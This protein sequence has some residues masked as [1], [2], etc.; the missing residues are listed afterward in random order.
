MQKVIQRFLKLLLISYV[1][2]CN[3]YCLERLVQG[4]ATRDPRAS[5]CARITNLQPASI[6]SFFMGCGSRKVSLWPASMLIQH[7]KNCIW[8]IQLKFCKLTY[9]IICHKKKY[10]L[11]LPLKLIKLNLKSF[12]LKDYLH[13]KKVCFFFFISKC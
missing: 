4:F 12:Y 7:T 11:I 6:F 5:C 8:F 3:V 13:C 2:K 1:F 9:F 10:S